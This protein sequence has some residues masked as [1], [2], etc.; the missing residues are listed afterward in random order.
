MGT[1]FCDEH[2]KAPATKRGGWLSAARRR[3]QVVRLDASNIAA[4]L[5]VGAKPSQ[6]IDLP[7]VDMLVLCAAEYQP[8]LM[9]FH[10]DV[11][12]C[13]LRD[14]ELD[15]TELRRA[16]MA[17]QAV[18]KALARKRRVLVTCQLGRN[19]SALVAGLALGQIS[20][21]SGDQIVELIRARRVT[22]TGPVLSNASFVEILRHTIG[23]GRAPRFKTRRGRPRAETEE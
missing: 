19:R 21:M 7:K 8:S 20:R 11:I 9:A 18:G 3:A 5:W 6:W 2:A 10:G 23:A 15:S 13:P 14:A 1:P 4:K 16:I 22:G 17:G 12:R